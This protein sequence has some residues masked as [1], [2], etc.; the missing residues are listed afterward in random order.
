MADRHKQD[1]RDYMAA[2]MRKSR[3]E[4]FSIDND[5][6]K[7]R[8]NINWRRRRKAEKSL[9]EWIKTYGIGVFIDDPP[10]K[11]WGE[12][13]LAEMDEAVDASRPYQILIARGGGKTSYTEACVAYNIATGRRRFCLISSINAKQAQQI[14]HE[15][16]AVFTSEPFATDYPDIAVPIKLLDGHGRRTQRYGGKDTKVRIVTDETMLPT[17]VDRD[18][19]VSIA[20]GACIRAKALKSVRGTKNGTQRPD[21]IV[22]DDLQTREIAE[23]DDRVEDVMKLIRGD[24]MGLAGKGKAS[25]I[26]TATTIAVGDITERIGADKGW[27]TTRNPAILSWPREWWKDGHG[28]WG[29]YFRLYD[30]ENTHDFKHTRR[31]GS[32]DFYRKNRKAMD[33]DAD[34][35]NWDNYK[36]EDGQISG[37]QKLMDKYHEMGRAAFMA[38]YMMT[39]LRRQFAF[40]ITS[41]RILERVRPGLAPHAIP[42]GFVFTCAATDINPSYALTT[43]ICHFDPVRTCVVT[44]HLIQRISIDD[45]VNDTVFSQK[46]YD[47]LAVHGRMLASFGLKLDAWGIDAGGKQWEAVNTFAANSRAACGLP[48]CALRGWSKNQFNPRPKSHVRD[49]I[50]N[51]V[52]CADPTKGWNWI[53][54]DSDT[55]K[56][57]VQRAFLTETGAPGGCSLFDGDISHDEFAVQVANESIMSISADGKKYEWK[58]KDPHDYLDCLGMCYAI[59][60]HFG[61]SGTGASVISPSVPQPAPQ[62]RPPR[63]WFT[64][65]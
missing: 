18:G 9:F 6:I 52:H 13:I 61:I 56:E 15:L 51:T 22:L 12:K 38:E 10:P 47:V 55:Y 32:L 53:N 19:T 37:L 29:E 41:Q 63:K 57:S 44:D 16:T 42:P 34:I 43:V 40:D 14:L 45:T 2:A 23:N 48:C 62:P 7:A 31:D 35:L 54:W 27:K 21:L 64:S 4:S 58:S 33:K 17:I 49:A 24:V 20:S 11:P 59:A 8:D 46:I 5:L 28:L 25:I 60:G 3:D 1:R 26:S 65:F 36:R 39:P 50:N 30:E